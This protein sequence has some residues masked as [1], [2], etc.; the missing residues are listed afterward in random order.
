MIST[1]SNEF[2]EFTLEGEEL[3]RASVFGPEQLAYLSNMRA[4]C[5]RT[6]LNLSGTK[7]EYDEYVEQV[8]HLK[9]QLAILELLI[10]NHRTAQEEL[11]ALA[12]QYS[13]Q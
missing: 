13:D 8:V 7:K 3:L 12:L 2:Q 11:T 10:N 9:G 4:E 6:I 1:K 5:A